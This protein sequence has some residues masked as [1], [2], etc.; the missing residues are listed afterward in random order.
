M[1]WCSLIRKNTTGE[2]NAVA[3]P[4]SSIQ[5]R[6]ARVV[7]AATVN[8]LR[9]AIIVLGLEAPLASATVSTTSISG[10]RRKPG[11]WENQDAATDQL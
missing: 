9:R 1:N 6:S 4:P 10:A 7:S 2:T 11:N 3:D 8:M 5:T